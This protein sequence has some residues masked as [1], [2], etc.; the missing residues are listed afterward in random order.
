MGS[1]VTGWLDACLGFTDLTPPTDGKGCLEGNVPSNYVDWKINF[2]KKST[3]FSGGKVLVRITA[4]PNWNGY[5]ES[6]TI[7]EF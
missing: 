4:G 1:A 6:I 2:G 7:T 5:I 3:L